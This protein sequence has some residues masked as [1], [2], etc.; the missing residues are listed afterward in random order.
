[1]KNKEDSHTELWES[2]NI[3]NHPWW[4]G[5]NITPLIVKMSFKDA[6]TAVD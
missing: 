2:V 4:I 6:F 3:I 5:F 1:M